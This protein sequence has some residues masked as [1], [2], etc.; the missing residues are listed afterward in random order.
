[1]PRIASLWRNL[2]HR[3]RVERDLDDEVRSAF[4]LLVDEK[5]ATGMRPEDARRAATLE[6]GRVDIVKEQVRAARAGASLDTLLQDIRH[7]L[8]LFRRAPGF[9]AVAIVTLALGIGANAAIFGALK[10]VL[11]DP[12][13]YADAGRLVH[14]D[15][16]LSAGTITEIA[17]RQR[18]FDTLTA[19]V[20]SASDAVY[21][22]EEG[23]RS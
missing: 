3:R 1:M 16:P 13:P 23:A 5:I 19:F 20:L 10:S 12:L 11:L 8:R 4:D 17:Q 7:S 2:V 9:T 6:I 14:V 18:S 15:G 21:G 22:G